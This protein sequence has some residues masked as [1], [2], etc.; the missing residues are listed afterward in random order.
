MRSLPVTALLC[1]ALAL[2]SPPARADAPTPKPLAVYS[3]DKV[4]IDDPVALS[5]DGRP[6]VYL[7]TDGASGSTLHLLALGVLSPE[8]TVPCDTITAERV[9]FLDDERVLVVSRDP[10]SRMATARVY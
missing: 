2:L 4:C 1:G 5:A 6:L 10:Q 9:D 7:T 3:A 8:V